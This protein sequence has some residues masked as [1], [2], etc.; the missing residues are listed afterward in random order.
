MAVSFEATEVFEDLGRYMRDH[1]EVV[2]RSWDDPERK[3]V[4]W[5]AID[6]D[7]ALI[8]SWQIPFQSLRSFLD[9][10]SDL[11][12]LL[13]GLIPTADTRKE[14]PRLLLERQRK[15]DAKEAEE[16]GQAKNRFDFLDEDL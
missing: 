1:P 3:R 16:R 5:A 8:R 2:I 10:D 13:I 4:G 7:G 9:S 11:V 12:S 14:I 6:S 15:F